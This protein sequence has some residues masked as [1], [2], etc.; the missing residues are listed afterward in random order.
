MFFTLMINFSLLTRIWYRQNKRDLPWR[1]T[2]NPY[3]IWLSEI[4]L[5]QTRVNQGLSYFLAFKEKYPTVKDLAKS[6]EREVL[7]LWQGLGYYSRARNLH[8]A[9]KQIMNDFKGEFPN[10]YKDLKKLKGVGDYTAAAIAS[11]S[12]DLPHAT[13][14]GNV[15]R[16]LSRFFGD[17]TPIDTTKGKKVF[18]A[19]A[20]EVLAKD[21][22]AEHNQ[23]IME[24]GALICSPKQ[25][26]CLSCPLQ[27][28]CLA[29]RKG[30]QHELP[31]K[32]KKTKVT[33][34][35]FN[36][37][38]SGKDN[39]MIIQR[40]KN[41]IWKNLYQFPLIETSE[42]AEIA[43]LK[44]EAS[45]EWGVK[46]VEEKPYCTYKHILSHQHI[47]AQFWKCKPI[48]NKTNK[49]IITVSIDEFDD[50]PVPRLIERFM[51]EN[52]MD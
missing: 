13:V 16:V 2:K 47:F 40:D 23:A 28:G 30:I 21:Q 3:F 42:K 20:N 38:F 48:K 43:L 7:K 18:D 4:I 14:D 33:K 45:K 19:Y 26:K 50:Y 25:P 34:R 6:N 15:Y 27:D 37:L 29:A 9:A 24:L 44:N 46:I 10:E 51:Q 32:S 11:F 8:A 36:Y 17:H 39:I 22:A 35:Y 31:A 41:G 12:F 49:S 1:T 52:E 5:Q